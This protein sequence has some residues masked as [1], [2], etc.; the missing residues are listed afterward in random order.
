MFTFKKVSISN[1]KSI[2][3]AELNLENQGLVLIEGKNTTNTTFQS[4]GSGKSSLLES[5]TYALYDTTPSGLTADKVVNKNVGKNTVVELDFEVDGLPYKIQR[6]R[7]HSKYKNTVKLWQGDIN[8]TGKSVKET[9]QKIQKLFGIDYQTYLNSIM[10]GQGDVEI[11]TKATDKGKKEILENI[12]NIAIYKQAQE[13]AKLKLNESSASLATVLQSITQLTSEEQSTNQLIK[14]QEDFIA[15]DK[16]EVKDLE[17]KLKKAMNDLAVKEP[18]HVLAIKKV[19]DN[20]KLLK[21]YKN[22]EF[23]AITPPDTSNLQAE[24]AHLEE[25]RNALNGGII[26][27]KT[28]L[29]GFTTSLQSLDTSDTCSYCGAPI[30]NTH[31][32]N[33]TARLTKEIDETNSKIGE[34]D[35]YV[36]TFDS[37]ILNK[38]DEIANVEASFREAQTKLYEL[39]NEIQH[40]ELKLQSVQVDSMVESLRNQVKFIESQLANRVPIKP[41]DYSSVLK[42]ITDKKKEAEE[43]VQELEK[44]IKDYKDIV[45][46]VFSNSGLRSVVLDLVT[47]FLNKQ[48]NYYLSRLADSDISIEFTTQKEK[49]DGTLSDQFDV[50]VTNEHG[51]AEYQANSAGE[52][53]RI[54]LAI[55][56]AIQDLVMSQ[57]NLSTNIALYDE[58]FDGLDAIGCENVISILKEKQKDVGSIFVITHNENLKPL[59]DNVITIEKTE[60]SSTLVGGN[61][62]EPKN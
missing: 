35:A 10:Y 49:A 15:R 38:K 11:F 33:E 1:F 12:T 27:L 56:L 48:A 59:F 18:A 16:A 19:E 57:S 45:N 29:E 13:Q 23:S 54:D 30:D 47:P 43:K 17:A 51:G 4:N 36:P 6:Y 32:L 58:C 37:L 34:L 52:K 22:K 39:N 9:N 14:Q 8:L 41:T 61:N 46:N 60:G 40:E 55:A 42:D 20:L 31:K 5:I 24:L 2:T 26:Q 3:H 62:D 21:D 44:D 7:K 28:R 50:Q 25:Q 53:K